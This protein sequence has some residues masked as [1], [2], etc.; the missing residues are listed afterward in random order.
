MHNLNNLKV[1]IGS[2]ATSRVLHRIPPPAEAGGFQIAGLIINKKKAEPID[3][4]FLDLNRLCVWLFLKLS[5][6]PC[7]TNQA[8]AKE[9]QTDRFGDSRD[10]DIIQY[11]ADIVVTIVLEC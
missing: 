8:K 11:R 3:P 10:C 1:T 6:Y 7:Q 4:A 9:E 5:P 2:S